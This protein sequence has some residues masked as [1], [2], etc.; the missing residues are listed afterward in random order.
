MKMMFHNVKSFI[1]YINIWSWSKL[2]PPWLSWSSLSN[3]T[4]SW[5][6]LIIV[7]IFTS[8]IFATSVQSIILSAAGRSGAETDWLLRLICKMPRMSRESTQRLPRQKKEGNV[9]H[10][11]RPRKDFWEFTCSLVSSA[12]SRGPGTTSPERRCRSQSPS[13]ST[14]SSR[15]T[16][17][18][19]WFLGRRQEPRRCW[20]RLLDWVFCWGASSTA[21]QCRRAWCDRHPEAF[22]SSLQHPASWWLTE[23]SPCEKK[24]T[25]GEAPESYILFCI[26][27]TLARSSGLQPETML[28]LDLETKF[29]SRCSLELS[30]EKSSYHSLY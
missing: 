15:S 11:S 23:H 5:W 27:N 22:P 28:A 4:W 18:G 17:V 29:R 20:Q 2:S 10:R 9:L 13:A 30:A 19:S 24:R 21:R 3:V 7:K 8:V 1:V 25:C 12:C 16:L 26:P 14:W 6:S